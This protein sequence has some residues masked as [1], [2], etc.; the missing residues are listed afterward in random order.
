MPV[1]VKKIWNEL[2]T[3]FPEG[4]AAEVS[5]SGKILTVVDQQGARL[6]RYTMEHVERYWVESNADP[7][8][9]DAAIER[10]AIPTFT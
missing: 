4:I 8:V 10:D 9:A 1:F 6:G 3:V 7:V 5:R 2:P